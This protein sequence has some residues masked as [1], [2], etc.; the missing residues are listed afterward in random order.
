MVIYKKISRY[1]SQPLLTVLLLTAAVYP[2]P[3]LP[4]L[5]SF[6]NDEGILSRFT[7]YNSDDPF[8][9]TPTDTRL[10]GAYV[11]K[12]LC[13]NDGI[14]CDLFIGARFAA[15]FKDTGSGRCYNYSG[16]SSFFLIPDCTPKHRRCSSRLHRERVS[17]N[18]GS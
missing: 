3:A 15:T 6:Y 18:T 17:P 12:T 4:Y 13:C 16:G 2:V 11:T 5:L 14:G 10:I 8:H 9:A 1:L 7:T